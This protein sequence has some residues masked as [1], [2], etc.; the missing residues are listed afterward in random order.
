MSACPSPLS[1]KTE[2]SELPWILP[3]LFQVDCPCRTSVTCLKKENGFDL[4]PNPTGSGI[5]NIEYL[6]QKNEE[7]AIS[8]YDVEGVLIFKQMRSVISGLNA[9]QFDLSSKLSGIYI[10][11]VGTNEWSVIEKLVVE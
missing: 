9:L 10:V 1:V 8:I 11:N 7:L 4:N 6:S 2:K 5:V 3:S